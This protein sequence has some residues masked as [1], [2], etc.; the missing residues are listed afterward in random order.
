MKC[1]SYMLACICILMIRKVIN[2]ATF[3]RTSVYCQCIVFWETRRA[4][5]LT[6]LCTAMLRSLR[7]I[8][9]SEDYKKT[10]VGE[11]LANLLPQKF[12]G[13]LHATLWLE[14]FDKS[15]FWNF[16]KSHYV[17]NIKDLKSLL[18]CK[19]SGSTCIHKIYKIYHGENFL[20]KNFWLCYCDT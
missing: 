6:V 18:H 11:N 17:L 16:R 7:H 9:A 19:V 10:F 13:I 12:Q 8:C 5:N 15:N 20:L 3:S 1:I 14:I 4:G 2:T